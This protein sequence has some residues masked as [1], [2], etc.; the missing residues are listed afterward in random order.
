MC[1]AIQPAGNPF[2]FAAA[3]NRFPGCATMAVFIVQLHC[4]DR[5]TI[6]EPQATQ[7]TPHLLVIAF[8]MGQVLWCIREDFIR[9]PIQPI[10]QATVP[11]FAVPERTNTRNHIQSAFGAKLDEMARIPVSTPIILTGCRFVIVPEKICRD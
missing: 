11:T 1:G 6:L 2:D 5:T 7:L 9:L 3:T 8:D 4:G 10:W